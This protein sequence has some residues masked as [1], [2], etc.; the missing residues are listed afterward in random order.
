MRR[1]I[2]VSTLV[3]VIVCG[4]IGLGITQLQSRAAPTYA[5]DVIAA[6][7]SGDT[8]GFARATNVRTF[9]FPQD[10][11]AH[12]D[13]QTEWWYYTGNLADAQGRRFGYQLTIFRRALAPVAPERASEWAT[14][15]MYFAHFAVS[16]LQAGQFHESDRYS[17]GANGL[18]GATVDPAANPTVRVWIEDWSMTATTTDAK[19][20]HL[21]AADNSKNGHFA[22]DFTVEQTKPAVLQGDRGLSAK[23]PE[24]GNASY[25][26]SLTRL[27][28][29]GT[30]TLGDQQ[31]TVVGDSWK[32]H[33]YSTSVL[34]KDAV[35]WDWF[36]L[37]LS[38][39]RE[40]MLYRIRRSD[41]S[42]EP[43]SDGTL[44]N[45]DGT[46]E[47]LTLQQYDI[48]QLRTWTSPH[49]GATYPSG[50]RLTIRPKVGASLSLTV[51]PLMVDQEINATGTYWEGA[52]RVSGT[53][54]GKPVTGYG[55]AELTGYQKR[56]T[57]PTR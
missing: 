8:T 41:G 43:T 40:L 56:D 44:V 50:W 49:S 13:F 42:F 10:F 38:D 1:R 57:L 47:H 25:Y 20:M 51:D 24:P 36:S 31:F 12:P 55:Y 35:G 23:S 3:I 15:Q 21:V 54:D 22:V 32:D 27:A 26:Y 19:V 33:E 17:R 9:V 14:N 37:Q 48:E 30:I 46:Y 28:T 45:S 29:K 2:L 5:A 11:G 4:V 7:S 53:Q 16:D 52:N 18:S 6:L 39:N 34:S